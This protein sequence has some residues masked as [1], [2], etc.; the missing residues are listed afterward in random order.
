MKK[1]MSHVVLITALIMVLGI[2]LFF[3]TQTCFLP[4]P[5]PIAEEPTI[6]HVPPIIE[7]PVP[8]PVIPIEPVPEIEP[9]EIIEPPVVEEPVVEVVEPEPIVEVEEPIIEEPVIEEPIIEE[10]IIEEPV[11]EE[12]IIE[13]PVIEE[14]VIEEPIIEEPVIEEPIIEEP[15]IEEPIIEE[16]VVEPPPVIEEPVIVVP[17]EPEVVIPEPEPEVVIPEPEPEPIAREIIEE[18]PIEEP[19]VEEEVVEVEPEEPPPPPIPPVPFLF[20]PMVMS[21]D[22]YN[23]FYAEPFDDSFVED[24]FWAD[25]F[26]V[27]EDSVVAYDDGFY[28]L[29]LFVNDERVGD[30][31]VEF[32]GETRW[33]NSEELF[34]YVNP[35]ITRAASERI[36]GDNLPSLSLEQLNER[37]VQASYDSS[38]FAIYLTFSLEDMPER[39]V[40]IT[41]TSINRRQQYGMSGAVVLKPVKLAV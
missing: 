30:V 24:D 2:T 29:N 7:E 22:E 1:D 36:F 37:G 39:M 28:F 18:E 27:G 15:V 11:I 13:E 3:F 41:T 23:L 14:P 10:P 40:S 21:E 38:A 4:K 31:E 12:P 35:H 33:I 25:F 32:E 8:T 19:I 26:I 5:A 34:F 16:P 20:E 17:V 9:I 6:V